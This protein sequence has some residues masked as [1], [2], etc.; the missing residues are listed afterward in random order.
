MTSVADANRAFFDNMSQ[1][2]RQDPIKAQWI[3]GINDKVTNFL[4]SH[5]DWVGLSHTKTNAPDRNIRHLDYA[6]G[7]G[8]LSRALHPYVTDTVGIDISPLT[9]SSYNTTNASLNPRHPIRAV[10]G[11]LLDKSD[12]NPVSLSTPEFFNF[13]IVTGGLA[14][15]HFEDAAYAAERLRK[16]LRPG[17]VLVLTDFL[18]GGD[19]LID[20]D[21]NVVEGSE[22]DHYSHI[23]RHHAN[24]HGHHHGH[25]HEHAPDTTAAKGDIKK[26]T[27]DSIVV[28]AFSIQEVKDFLANAGFVDIDVRVMP[29]KVFVDFGKKMLRTIMFAKGRNPGDGKDEL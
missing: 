10:V 2:I 29:E 11:S 3:A 25:G 7:D 15:H 17:G 14:F 27:M 26:H 1:T 20:D 9:V 23:R 28:T 22:G 6:C 8:V 13:D 21:G 5:I 18:T 24:G 4:Q 16:R 12:P 19:M